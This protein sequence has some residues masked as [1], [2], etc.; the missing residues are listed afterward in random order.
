M[1]I[2][3]NRYVG[4]SIKKNADIAIDNFKTKVEKALSGKGIK[5]KDL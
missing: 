4:E 5:R 2:T 3:V 1:H